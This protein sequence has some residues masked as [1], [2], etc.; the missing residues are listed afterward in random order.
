M[1]KNTIT[2]FLLIGAILLGFTVYN[3]NQAEKQKEI[4][5]KIDSVNY[6]NKQR[7]I[8]EITSQS[9]VLA[10]SIVAYKK[11]SYSTEELTSAATGKEE[12]YTLE[13]D[14]IIVK[15]S[16]KGAS[17]KSVE[18][19]GY[20]TYDEKP[21]YL[22]KEKDAV[23]NLSFFTNSENNTSNFYFN[24]KSGDV[25]VTQQSDSKSMILTLPLSEGSSIDY[26]YT[27]TGGSN[28]VDFKIK[29]N[30]ASNVFAPNQN[31]LFVNW[32]NV[33]PQQEKGF[34]YENT[35]TT[36]GYMLANES[37][38]DELS[39]SEG[40]EHEQIDSKVRWVAFKQ[41]FFSSVLIAKDNFNSADVTFETFEP[42]SGN[43]KHFHAKLSLPYSMETTEYDLSFYF[44]ANKYS[45][46]KEY[47]EN[48]EKLVPLGW[49]IFGWVN[50][51]IVIPA[52]NFLGEYISSYGL[53]ILLLTIYIKILL[54]G[55][56]YK[57]YVSMAK[58]RIL[59]PEIDE[60]SKQYPDKS[61][62]V[63]KQQA[64][65]ELYRKGGVNP[66]GG[67]L[68]MLLQ[69]PIIIAMFRFFPA[70]IELRDKSFL[71][72]DD[73]SS[74]D[75]I[76]SLPFNI[77]F[78]GDHVSL[79][80]LL[81]GVSVIISSKMNMQNNASS[82]QQ[83]PGMNF[84]MIYVMPVMLVVWFNSYSSGLSY[85]YLLSN[86]ITIGQTLIIRRFV[87]DNKLHAQMKENAK[88]PKKKSKWA[89]RYDDMVKQ[90]E[91]LKQDQ[92]KKR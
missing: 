22:F 87:D 31:N 88:K 41:Q 62:A 38:L 28:M 5:H 8:V 35:Y 51:F 21:L 17:I 52:F 84:M 23:F 36:I 50:R 57:S 73:L 3:S 70:S 20:N 11:A 91:K 16:N 32:S 58:M 37:S 85:Y 54:F 56:T 7:D 89:S 1:D 15:V 25:K 4:Q 6:V 80:A 53:I 46:L 65:M 43:M 67:C 77:P 19:K 59:K 92:S 33:S 47:D 68:P 64:T 14:K 12:F 83:M 2:G 24:N 9:D 48:L 76:L 71:W 75:S 18:L 66:L 40:T 34:S 90:Q 29:L 10:D 78:Y 86:I 13:N 45:E 27:I 26:I 60:I 42:N 81:M 82:T 63:K 49:G 30:G 39:M 61:D 55:F 69:M 74:Y 44:G 72:A 79:F